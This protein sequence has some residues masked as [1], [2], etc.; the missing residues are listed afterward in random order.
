MLESRLASHEK[1]HS[2]FMLRTDQRLEVLLDQSNQWAGVRKTLGVLVG[3]IS[4]VGGALGWIFHEVFPQG[5][6][7]G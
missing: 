3:L 2:E 5:V 6:H 1:L 7:G 4:L